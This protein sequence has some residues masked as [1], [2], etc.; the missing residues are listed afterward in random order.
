LQA[1]NRLIPVFRNLAFRF[2]LK[3]PDLR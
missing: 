3:L 1:Y 2:H